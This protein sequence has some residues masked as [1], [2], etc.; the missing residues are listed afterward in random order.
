MRNYP[1]P[2]D[3]FDAPVPNETYVAPSAYDPTQPHHPHHHHHH[4][5]QVQQAQQA[6]GDPN[7]S[8]GSLDGMGGGV[9]GIAAP[10]LSGGS[11]GMDGIEEDR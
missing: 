8:G 1:G 6:G 5:P 4:H 9:A 10:R 7:R 2:D 3:V 11:L